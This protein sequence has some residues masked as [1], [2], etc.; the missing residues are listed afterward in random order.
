MFSTSL[1]PLYH[2]TASKQDEFKTKRYP[3]LLHKR[4]MSDKLKLL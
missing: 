2:K 1:L 3:I 4:N